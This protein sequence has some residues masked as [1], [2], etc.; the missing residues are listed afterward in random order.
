MRLI[1]ILIMKFDQGC[2]S[3]KLVLSKLVKLEDF[4]SDVDI[5]P[6]SGKD[7]QSINVNLYNFINTTI[8]SQWPILVAQ[9]YIISSAYSS[10]SFDRTTGTIS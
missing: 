5:H 8:T 7:Y 6:Y 9:C 4:I 10:G 3:F 2:H 1:I